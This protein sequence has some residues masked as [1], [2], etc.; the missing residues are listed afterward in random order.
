MAGLAL[1]RQHFENTT[2]MAG[3]AI[4]QVM[5]AC[6]RKTG[7]EMIKGGWISNGCSKRGTGN[8][9]EQRHK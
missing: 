7:N 4:D 5:I 9:R 8:Y 3:F 1:R 2:N 6:E